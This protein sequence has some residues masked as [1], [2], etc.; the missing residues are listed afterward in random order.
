MRS[1]R[2]PGKNRA[3]CRSVPPRPD[4]DVLV[5][6]AR[7][8]DRA[9]VVVAV[10]LR[11]PERDRE[12]Q[13]RRAEQRRAQL[14]MQRGE[15]L[16]GRLFG[17][18]RVGPEALERPVHRLIGQH[19]IGR[20][21][22]SHRSF[23]DGILFAPCLATAHDLASTDSVDRSRCC[24]A[25]PWRR[26]IGRARP[27]ARRRRRARGRGATCAAPRALTST[28]TTRE[29]GAPTGSKRRALDDA[30]HEVTAD[31]CAASS[32]PPASS[33]TP[34]SAA[35]RWPRPR[36]RALTEIAARLLESRI[37]PRVGRARPSPR[38]RRAA[39]LRR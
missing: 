5:R 24:N 7:Q 34:I 25:R 19:A 31:R 9:R 4:L 17:E 21:F 29:H 26:A 11:K 37:R 20:F 8:L 6:R 14:R 18:I 13:R 16:V 36:S 27:A 28:V 33:C 30:A 32:T 35:R 3:R 15:L 2:S 10:E 23:V 1:G 39:A 22:A 38:S 12:R